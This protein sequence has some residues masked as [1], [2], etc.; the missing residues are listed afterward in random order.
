[1][2]VCLSSPTT[3]PICVC[4]YNLVVH[5]V[6]DKKK[7][8][9]LVYLANETLESCAPAWS[10]FSN[11]NQYKRDIKDL[12]ISVFRHLGLQ[13]TILL[14]CITFCDIPVKTWVCCITFFFLVLRIVELSV[15]WLKKKRNLQY[16]CSHICGITLPFLL[17]L[18]HAGLLQHYSQQ[19]SLELFKGLLNG[20][21]IKRL[22]VLWYL[23]CCCCCFYVF[24]IKYIVSWRRISPLFISNITWL[25]TKISS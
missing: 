11:W 18:A 15:I 4:P 3:W 16:S 2:C 6:P 25:F 5:Q 24:A 9:L 20:I 13:I 10:Q 22:K 19:L 1:M 14:A 8:L 7:V 17:L 12:I 21:D 23:C